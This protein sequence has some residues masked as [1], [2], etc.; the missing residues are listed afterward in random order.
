MAPSR[1]SMASSITLCGR[2]AVASHW[3]FMVSMAVCMYIVRHLA[4]N[5]MSEKTQRQ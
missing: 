2:K 3:W 5:G 1:A 4:M